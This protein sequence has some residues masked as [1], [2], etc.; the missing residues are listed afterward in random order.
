MG[1]RFSTGLGPFRVSVPLTG[2]R[3]RRATAAQQ[4]AP[5]Q[6]RNPRLDAIF[7]TVGIIALAGAVIGMIVAMIVTSIR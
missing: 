5:Y 6:P 4:E 3:R 2:G 7:I 1:V